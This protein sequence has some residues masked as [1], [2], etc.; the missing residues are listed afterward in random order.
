MTSVDLDHA[1]EVM[2][3]A[4]KFD[5]S[6][7]QDM[8]FGDPSDKPNL[9]YPPIREVT[10]TLAARGEVLNTLYDA[11][12]NGSGVLLADVADALTDALSK[13]TWWVQY[14]VIVIMEF[15]CDDPGRRGDIDRVSRAVTRMGSL[16]RGVGAA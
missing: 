5:A 8:M 7:I 3:A 15:G 14:Q 6:D 4:V 2:E 11:R 10:A 12:E 13:I 9:E 1:I 16:L